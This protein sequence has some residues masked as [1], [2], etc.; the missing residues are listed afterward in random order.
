MMPAPVLRLLEPDGDYGR[1]LPAW[2]TIEVGGAVGEQLVLRLTYDTS[3][4]TWPLLVDQTRVVLLLGGVEYP[5]C[6]FI[7]DEQD[8]DEVVR[9]DLGSWA[10]NS[11]LFGLNYAI[12]YPESWTIGVGNVTT[13]G[14]GFASQTPGQ[15]LRELLEAAQTRGWWPDLTW[16]FTDAVDSAGNT[17]SPSISE[18]YDQGTTLLEVVARWKTRQLAVAKMAGDVLQLFTY[19]AQGTDRSLD[20]ILKRDVEL[21]EGPVKR[22]SRNTVSTLLVV[23]ETTGVE[24][25]SNP[26][27][28]TY[29]RREGFVSQ[30]SD[31]D[32][33]VLQAIGDGTLALKARQR[34]SFT[35]GLGG[36]S[37]LRPIVDFD[38][39]DLVQLWVRGT[40]RFMRV[41]Q[42]TVSW[43]ASGE[44]SGSAAFGDRL[45]DADEQ[46]ATRLEQLTGGSMDAGVYAPP[47]LA[48]T[49]DQAPG[50]GGDDGV[51]DTM[52]PGPP[53]GLGSTTVAVFEQGYLSATA[54]LTWVAPTIDQDG[55]AVDSLGGFEVQYRHT[56]YPLWEAGGRYAQDTLAAVIRRLVVGDDYDW[57]V[58]AFDVWGNVSTWATGTFT[59]DNDVILPAQTPST[60][61]VAPFLY[62]GLLVTWDGKAQGGTAIDNDIRHVEVHVSTSSGFAPG[63]T[64]LK[65]TI[66]IGG[67]QTV[68]AELTGGTT[69]YV[70]FRSVDWAGNLG[71]SSAQATGVPDSLVNDI[72]NGSITDAKIGTLSVTK[73]TTGTLTAVVTN[74][75][76]IQTAA[77]GARTLINSAGIKLFDAASNVTVAMNSAD[78]TASFTGIIGA[79]TI[80]GYVRVTSGTSQVLVQNVGSIPTVTLTTGTLI[81]KY[82][83]YLFCA[84]NAF[85]RHLS[86]TINS[87]G[88]Q[89]E[90]TSS[91]D[92]TSLQ[93][94]TNIYDGDF[95]NATTLP[96]KMWG[97]V[98]FRF[99]QSNGPNYPHIRAQSRFATIA[100]GE[101]YELYPGIVWR[102]GSTYQRECG[103]RLAAVGA[104]NTQDLCRLEVIKN[105][106]G[107]VGGAFGEI[108]ASAFTVAS[109]R[110]AKTDVAPVPYSALQV[111]RA[112]P[113]KRWRY[114]TEPDRF[115][116]G[117]MA[118]G[119]P[120]EVASSEG[121]EVG[122][123]G[124]VN[125][126]VRL[127]SMIGLLW[128]AVE[129]LA[130][131]VEVRTR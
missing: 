97:E 106:A 118:D 55:T 111:I 77:S 29:G 33:T 13:P 34:E 31:A 3:H 10:G 75:G 109:G 40:K 96:T 95:A 127:N 30:S 47:I 43:A 92:Y 6:R 12:V 131:Q 126:M 107:V 14:W 125:H 26:A 114:R 15:A 65:D 53:T 9:A 60:P 94:I 45:A 71:P 28:S 7:L 104:G 78:G 8:D 73:L 36:T 59:A 82:P 79:A 11:L 115:E 64:T 122:M 110:A 113:A 66:G 63:P 57:R 20:V 99:P 16:D 22:S 50:G 4:D 61:T 90:G 119:L 62:M 37:A 98:H 123:P 117:P 105:N 25:T 21:T 1:V 74:S 32:T 124:E 67:G 23:T 100:S 108:A 83:A 70:K 52:P 130:E 101:D 121:P 18:F 38:R 24:R 129:E 72:P 27:L 41:R 5:D 112:N 54:T 93:V 19:A 88:S 81:E 58:R 51:I 87:P 120:P 44:V 116:L 128:R 46:L 48:G 89:Y 42:L 103:I 2:N 91:F 85:L 56:G 17:W 69:Y 68:V 76:T 84:T 35:Y 49:N 102:D 86:T 80:T 39:G